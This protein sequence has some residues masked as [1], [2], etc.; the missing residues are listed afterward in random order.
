MNSDPPIPCPP[1]PGDLVPPGRSWET[2]QLPED[3]METCASDDAPVNLWRARQ[4]EHRLTTQRRGWLLGAV[5]PRTEA[6]VPSPAGAVAFLA[7]F[8]VGGIDGAI[9]AALVLYAWLR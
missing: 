9:V 7:G 4:V 5:W 8:V 6:L 2:R 3:E 1:D